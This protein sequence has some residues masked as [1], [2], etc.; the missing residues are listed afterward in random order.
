MVN[1]ESGE[2]GKPFI[3]A[4][5]PSDLYSQTFPAI[6]IYHQAIFIEREINVPPR[7]NRVPPV[8]NHFPKTSP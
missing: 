1:K 3:V 7:T 6:F 5:V 2:L 4:E 8:S